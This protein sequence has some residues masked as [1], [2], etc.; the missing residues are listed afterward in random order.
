MTDAIAQL[1]HTAR[2]STIV[3]KYLVGI[4]TPLEADADGG[5]DIAEKDYGR[6]PRGFLV[7]DSTK[8]PISGGNSRVKVLISFESKPSATVCSKTKEKQ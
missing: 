8:P 7:T 4:V 6:V 1:L 3:A 2:L 5:L